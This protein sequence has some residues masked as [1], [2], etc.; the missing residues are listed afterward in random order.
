MAKNSEYRHSFMKWFLRHAG[1]FPVRRYT[2]DVLAIRNA[3][4]VVEHGHILGI[5]P[6]GERTWDGEML[7]L[8][9]GTIRLI[10]ALNTP[11]IPVGITGAYSLMPR[12]TPAIKLSPV[13][14]AIGKP[15]EFAHIPIPMQTK[16][17]IESASVKLRTQIQKLAGGAL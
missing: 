1:S 6:E 2:V 17:D 16:D 15:M 13:K 10:L 11:V 5:F 12:W 3:I 7:P 14:I 9:T 4:R 8:R